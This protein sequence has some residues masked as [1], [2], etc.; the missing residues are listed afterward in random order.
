[1]HLYLG[2]CLIQASGQPCTDLSW[3]APDNLVSLSSLGKHPPG[4][5]CG[6]NYT[7][8]CMVH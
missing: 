3:P 2:D 6:L 8:A 1:M 5:C 7:L 4:A